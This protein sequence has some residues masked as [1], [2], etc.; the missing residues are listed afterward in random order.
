MKKN[1]ENSKK[2][3]NKDIK[4]KKE[5]LTIQN[6]QINH[7]G[8]VE[9]MVTQSIGAQMNTREIPIINGLDESLYMY[10]YIKF[11]L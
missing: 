10:F 1:G 5:V 2:N 3:L 4:E 7:A 9:N 8:H 6:M 11:K